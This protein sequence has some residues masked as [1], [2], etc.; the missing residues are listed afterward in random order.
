M[1]VY[2]KIKSE[3]CNLILA[4]DR[5]VMELGLIQDKHSIG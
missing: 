3:F 5:D 2:F 4:K 1:C